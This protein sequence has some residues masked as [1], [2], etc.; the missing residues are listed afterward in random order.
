MLF[1]LDSVTQNVHFILVVEDEEPI[2]MALRRIFT[3]RGWMVTEALD[4]T[5]ALEQLLAP[6]APAYDVVL[7]DLRM[8]G[9]GGGELY[10]RIRVERPALAARMVF[11]T[12]DVYAEEAQRLAERSGC[13]LL[14]KPFDLHQLVALAERMAAA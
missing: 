4:G 5:T 11:S 2:R 13:V 6:D 9:M 10:D 3:R 14:Q 12:G 7:S 8:P 1:G